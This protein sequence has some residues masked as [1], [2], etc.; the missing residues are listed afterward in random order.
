ME[1]DWDAVVVG[2]GAAG[3]SAAQMLGRSLRRTLVVDGGRPR[4]RFAAH[5]HGVL[6]H[7]GIEPARLLERGRAEARAYG[8]EFAEGVVMALA[9]DGDRLLVTM[10]DGRVLRTRAAVVATGLRDDLPD[11]P[12]LAEEWGRTVL[13]CPYCHGREVAGRRLGVL[14]VSAASTHQVQLVR[15]L[16]EDV[17]AFTAAAE[18]LGDDAR[19]GLAA[20]G[21]RTVTAPVRG[22]ERRDDGI[23]LRTADG[24]EHLVGAVFTGGAPELGLDFVAP[25]ELARSDQPGAPLLVDP[26]GRTSH[27]RVFAAGNAVAPFGN[28]PVSMASGSMAGAGVNAALVAEDVDLARA[29]RDAIRNAAWEHRHVERDGLWSGEVNAAVAEVAVGLDAGTALDVGAGEGGD[30]VWLAER[31][32]S[33]T[34]VDVAPTAIARA[35][36]L[37]RSRGVEVDLRVGD[38]AAAVEDHFDLVLASFLHS[39]EPD[40][41]RLRLLREA[42][43]RV[44]PGGRLLLVTHASVPTSS[45][46]GG[47]HGHAPALRRPEEDL[48]LLALDPAVWT[49]E[50]CELLPRRA[51]LP[52]GTDVAVEDGVLLLRRIG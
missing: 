8:V 52:D 25:L 14:A 9:D 20:R 28:V 38:G 37:A 50:R 12:G 19:S 30:A 32:W 7:D 46:T 44:A 34:A 16:S 13:H 41:P 42:A 39:P 26:M 29:A 2:G 47:V 22:L 51:H 21:I 17:V 18:P 10:D 3:L 33:V 1:Q 24:V 48:A 36:E 43:D 35:G 15:Q 31:G 11:V 5:M 45:L 27:P 23:V 40:F 6:G 49:A 4:N